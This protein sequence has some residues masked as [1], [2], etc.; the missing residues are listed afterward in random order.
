MRCGLHTKLIVI[1]TMQVAKGTSKDANYSNDYVETCAFKNI[2]PETAHEIALKLAETG[3]KYHSEPESLQVLWDASD[4]L[5]LQYGL[6]VIQKKKDKEGV[7]VIL[8]I[9]PVFTGGFLR[10][11]EVLYG[12]G[13]RSGLRLQPGSCIIRIWMQ[14]YG[15]TCCIRSHTC[16]N[17]CICGSHSHNRNRK[18]SGSHSRTG[19]GTGE[20]H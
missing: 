20:H 4:V 3:K 19:G 10:Y 1:D 18:R 11:R 12:K 17:G 6:C 16:W 13:K 7:I 5:C 9:L 8:K 14:L 2:T 15:C